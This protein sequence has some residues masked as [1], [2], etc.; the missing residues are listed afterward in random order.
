MQETSAIGLL[1]WGWGQPLPT[2]CNSISDLPQATIGDLPLYLISLPLPYDLA[3][4]QTD[5]IAAFQMSE[6]CLTI[7]CLSTKRLP[8]GQL[9]ST[10]YF[11]RI[12]GQRFHIHLVAD[13]V[14]WWSWQGH[15]IIP[16][17]IGRQWA[18][19][20]SFWLMYKEHTLFPWSNVISIH[21]TTSTP[22]AKKPKTIVS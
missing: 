9:P 22:P 7:F 2:L 3:F 17:L 18:S 5:L 13:T 11:D 4:R 10:S 12:M 15:G 20:D 1:K 16:H 19:I 14:D 8:L 6:T 21:K